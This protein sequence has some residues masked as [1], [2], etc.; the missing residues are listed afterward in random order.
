MA[1]STGVVAIVAV[2]TLFVTL[3]YQYVIHPAYLSPLAP[4][5]K[6]H[7]SV[8]YSRLWVLAVRFRKTENRTLHAAH[9]RLGPVIRVAP[10]EL[11]IDG[12]DC[13]RTVYTGGF[14]KPVWYSV[15][16]NYG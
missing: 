9:K 16:D 11:S 5:P 6:A 4:I 15:F 3:V 14:E 1:H 12:V 10:Y 8:P 7:W 2:V 13:V